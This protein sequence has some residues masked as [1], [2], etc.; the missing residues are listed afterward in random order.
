MKTVS[1]SG[2]LRENVGKKDAKKQR[3]EGKVPCVLYGNGNQTHFSVE[4]SS[5]KPL[6][7]TPEVHFVDL[8]IGGKKVSAILQDIQYHP[9]TERILHADFLELNESKPIIMSIP[10]RLTGTSMGVL[11]G[12]KLVLKIKRV[13]IRALP[14]F[15]PE[16]I[17][18]DVTN[19][20]VLQGIKVLDVPTENIE[21]LEIKSSEIVLVKST[22]AVA[23]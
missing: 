18:L 2:S 14:K 16:N 5:F 17:T 8:T 19:L 9:V 4:E 20:D 21:I 6:I 11:Q 23:K 10:V 7:F 1:M 12:G 15:M 3:V 22:R 13:K